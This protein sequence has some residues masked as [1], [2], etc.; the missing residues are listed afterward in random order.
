MPEERRAILVSEDVGAR[1]RETRE[2]ADMTLRELV[3]ERS[4]RPT[5]VSYLHNSLEH[6][7]AASC[8]LAQV[9]NL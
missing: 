8:I 3:M 1:V 2:D 7:D 4:P 5:I 6:Y 9:P